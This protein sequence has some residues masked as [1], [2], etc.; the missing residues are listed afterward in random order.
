MSIFLR[1]PP[2][3][4]KEW[5]RDCFLKST[6]LTLADGDVKVV[7]IEDELCKET[8]AEAGMYDLKQMR[9][10]RDPVAVRIGQAV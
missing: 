9:W 3:S 8:L 4:M 7:F 6:K 10:L 1:K 5:Q 2:E